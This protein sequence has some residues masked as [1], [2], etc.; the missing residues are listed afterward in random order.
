[1]RPS[2][3]PGGSIWTGEGP[4]AAIGARVG[5]VPPPDPLATNRRRG[6]GSVSLSRSSASD[7]PS[8]WEAPCAI[9]FAPTCGSPGPGVA[10]PL[11]ALMWWREG[12]RRTKPLRGEGLGLQADASPYR[13]VLGAVLLLTRSLAQVFE[14]LRHLIDGVSLSPRLPGHGASSL[15]LQSGDRGPHPPGKLLRT[16][17]DAK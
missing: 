16:G 17:Y 10:P 9:S 8:R 15:L 3:G 13:G 14:H 11:R 5:A 6:R 7:C 2:G 12:P 1:M 4:S